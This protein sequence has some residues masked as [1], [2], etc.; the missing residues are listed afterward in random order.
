MRARRHLAP[1]H[2]AEGF[3]AL[4]QED[5][6]DN[7]QDQGADQLQELRHR[8]IA[9]H[10]RGFFHHHETVDPKEAGD[11]KSGD[12]KKEPLGQF[13]PIDQ[14]QN[15]GENTNA[16]VE[17]QQIA[18]GIEVLLAV[19]RQIKH[20][21][22][23]GQH[24]HRVLADDGQGNHATHDNGDLRP[25]T[26]GADGNRAIHVGPAVE[27]EGEEGR[28][29]DQVDHGVLG[30]HQ[31]QE[32]QDRVE[33]GPAH[34]TDLQTAE[35]QVVGGQPDG[36]RQDQRQEDPFDEFVIALGPR[37]AGHAAPQIVIGDQ[38]QR[39][40]QH[41]LNDE[42]P[43]EIAAHHVVAHHRA[44][45]IDLAA[46]IVA[47][48]RQRDQGG[49]GDEIG[50]VAH[51]VVMGAL[52]GGFGGDEFH[53]RIRAGDQPAKGQIAQHAVN[54]DRGGEDIFKRLP[55]GAD[56]DTIGVNAGGAHHETGPA[57]GQLHDGGA[58]DVQQD[59]DEDMDG[60]APLDDPQADGDR[61][62]IKQHDEP[63]GIGA[64]FGADIPAQKRQAEGRDDKGK[65]LED[66]AA[67]GRERLAALQP[68]PAVI[69]EV[70]TEGLA[71]EQQGIHEHDIFEDAGHVAHEGRVQGK[72]REGQEPA[73]GRR[74]GIGDTQQAG[75]FIGQLV[76]LGVIVFP[77]DDL[78]DHRKQRHAK[79]KCPEEQMH[80]GQKPHQPPGIEPHELAVDVFF[81]RQRRAHGHGY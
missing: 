72:Q 23:H 19:R 8:D 69:V 3:G 79:H 9:Q 46:K 42:G 52:L 35:R 2:L 26:L 27:Q 5:V 13:S 67:G 40:H 11:V 76:E 43:G 33:L 48:K 22:V 62:N 39:A 41:R 25:L 68:F 55:D 15:D 32:L 24:G 51:P 60:F 80:L 64:H 65:S 58:K 28:Q 18:D 81:L 14:G 21:G 4:E 50:D 63:K 6:D 78:D 10:R 71:K 31:P 70:K 37:N 34:F 45:R 36:K 61:K 53:R 57:V 12:G 56:K 7:D 20:G 44:G 16:H 54:G 30:R 47:G 77:A 49:D 73:K 1:L 66:P 59:A 38:E 74:G 75:E 17:D 29:D